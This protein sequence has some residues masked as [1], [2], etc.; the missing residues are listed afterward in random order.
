MDNGITQISLAD[1]VGLATPSQ[2]A[3]VTGAVLGIHDTVEIGLHLH[4]RPEEA[5][6]KIRA[7]YEA[8]CRRFDSTLGGHGGCPLA[9]DL[10]V[11]NVPTEVLISELR[12][13]G[14]ELPPLR[15]LDTLLTAANGIAQKFGKTPVH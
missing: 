7:A 4:T 13:L 8:G 6:A 14:A 5:A 11:G 9:Q 12:L 2:I 10:L 3:H 15:P 1:T